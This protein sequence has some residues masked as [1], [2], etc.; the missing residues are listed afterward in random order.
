MPWETKEELGTGI[1]IIKKLALVH[2][3]YTHFKIHMSVFICVLPSED[4]ELHP[5]EGLPWQWIT[6]DQLNDYP[7]PKANHK[8][9]PILREFFTKRG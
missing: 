4:E 5:P 2:H 8:F 9:F 7:F 6:V 3:A 1:K